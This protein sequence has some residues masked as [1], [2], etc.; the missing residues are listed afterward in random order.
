MDFFSRTVHLIGWGVGNFRILYLL[1]KKDQFRFY[2]IY[3]KLTQCS[4]F[5]SLQ[6]AII[7]LIICICN[8]F[9]AYFLHIFEQN[10]IT[11][12]PR[13]MLKRDI[14][15]GQISSFIIVF[16]T[17]CGLTFLKAP[18][19]SRNATKANLL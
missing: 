17:D 19:I 18:S 12:T 14:T 1:V 7:A 9:A 6:V 5:R 8:S 11:L 4:N 13:S 10:I 3:S 15:V 2:R 16:I